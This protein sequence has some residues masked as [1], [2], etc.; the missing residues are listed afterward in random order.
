[1][2][3]RLGDVASHTF[4][5][6][7]FPTLFFSGLRKTGTVFK[8]KVQ[9]WRVGCLGLAS[10]LQGHSLQCRVVGSRVLRGG[11]PATEASSKDFRVQTLV[12]RI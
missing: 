7:T 9:V 5:F 6:A 3:R 4:L 2:H 1:M 11:T 10:T 12:L 8:L